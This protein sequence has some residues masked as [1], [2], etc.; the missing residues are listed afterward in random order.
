MVKLRPGK[1]YQVLVVN[2]HHYVL[3]LGV[4]ANGQAS[5]VWK[6]LKMKTLVWQVVE[7]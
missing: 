6:L 2:L 4:K 7:D 3:K 5:K 1:T